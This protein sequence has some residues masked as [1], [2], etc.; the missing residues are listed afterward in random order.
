MA[1]ETIRRLSDDVCRLLIAGAHLAPADADLKKDHEALS[2]LAR[3]VGDK[4]PVIGKLAEA[5]GKAVNAPGK[6]AAAEVLGLAMMAAQV[7][8]AQ[9]TPAAAAA[10]L[11]VLAE[12]PAVPTACNAKDLDDLHAALTE[13]GQGR[14]EIIERAIE[15]GYIADLRLVEA[16]IFAMGDSWVGDVVSDRAIPAMGRAVVAPIR[17][18]LK[19]KGGTSLDARRLR[20][21]VAVEKTGAIDVLAQAV[22]DGAAPLREA[23]MDSIADHVAGVPE[24]EPYALEIVAKDKVIDTRR[25]AIRALGGYASDASLEAML[26]ALDSAHL[27]KAA[28]EGLG[29]SRHPRAVDRI[30][31]RL[32][33][34]VAAAKGAKAND[35]AKVVKAGKTAAK[36]GKDAKE[37]AREVAELLLGA[38]AKHRDPAIAR[39]VMELVPTYGARAARAALAS[40]DRAQLAAIADLFDGDDAG[41]YAVA[42]AAAVELGGDETFARLSAPFKKRGLLQRAKTDKETLARIDAVLTYYARNA[43]ALDQRWRDFFLDV[44][45]KGPREHAGRVVALLGAARERR[46]V[47]TL[48][49]MLAEET[50]NDAIVPIIQALGEIGDP[51]ALDAL[52]GVAKKVGHR[53]GWAIQRAILSIDHPSSVD[54]VRT[55]F[56]GL[57][58]GQSWQNW[59]IRSLLKTLESRYPGA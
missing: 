46:A 6:A 16:L 19:L 36:G 59:Y 23:A 52:V 11:Q 26:D 12:V 33:E 45:V 18:H 4:A 53:V 21:L 30:L 8:A 40:A 38:L 31:G 42:V 57:D 22:K 17:Q 37:R 47:P 43:A 20:A 58:N 41:N 48:L 9:A 54:K 56:V 51:A 25:A 44:L 39:A 3:Q 32:G 50:K 1:K 14:K 34:A 29:S 28:A 10:E 55:L 5:A 35:A 2:A 24:F 13:K 27:V 49:E 15:G 7:R